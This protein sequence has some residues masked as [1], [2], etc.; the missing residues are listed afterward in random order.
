[1]KT[2]LFQFVLCQQNLKMLGNEIRLHQFANGIHIHVFEVVVAVATTANQAV[3]F[4]LFF[5]QRILPAYLQLAPLPNREC[6]GL[7]AY[8]RLCLA[9]ESEENLRARY[10]I[11]QSVAFLR[12]ERRL[13]GSGNSSSK[14]K[15]IWI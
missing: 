11:L 14:W 12:S 6:C 8:C 4:L 9:E 1:M 10:T 13:L 2:Y 5:F 7:G 15:P 3:D